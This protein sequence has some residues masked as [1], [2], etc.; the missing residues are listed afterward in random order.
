MALEKKQENSK[1]FVIG[2]LQ[3]AHTNRRHSLQELAL[4]CHRRRLFS[5][6][7]SWRFVQVAAFEDTKG[8][9]SH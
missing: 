7:T 4:G 3:T 2:G 8:K 1:W 6:E 9:P 5:G